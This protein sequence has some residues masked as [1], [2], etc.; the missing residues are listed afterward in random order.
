[1][2]SSSNSLDKVVRLAIPSKGR[3]RE[4]VINLLEKAGVKI[5]LR[6][7]NKLLSSPTSRPE[8]HAVFMRAEDI[9]TFVEVGAADIGITGLDLIIDR[10]ADVEELL[11]LR[12]G[13]AEVVLAVSQSSNIESI[14][15]LPDEARI[16]TRYVNLARKFL[17][18]LAPEKRFRIMQIG[19]AAEIM[20]MLGVADAIID[21]RSTGITLKTHGLKVIEVLLRSSARLIANRRLPPSKRETVEKLR[22]M[23]EGVLNASKKKMIMMNVPDRF[24]K[25]VIEVIPSMSGPTIA[26]VEA[27]E[28]MWEVYAVV[29]E[30]EV[31]DVVLEVKRRGARDIL[32]LDIEKIVP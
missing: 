10:E 15:D 12:I 2:S 27:R 1:M 16:A 21:V 20:P 23:L 26:K 25:S 11:D 7:E 29:D 14:H 6:D 4:P 18:K 8:I 30:E 32:I 17:K 5:L 13:L 3:L 22:L 9:P 19:G 28:P 24:L 31:Y